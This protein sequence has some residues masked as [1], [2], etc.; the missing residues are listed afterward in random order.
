MAAFLGDSDFPTSALPYFK[1]ARII[2]FHQLYQMYSKLAF[3][4]P[5]DRSVALIGLEKR[6]SRTFDTRVE[7]GIVEK[8][9]ERDLLWR[10]DR[11][12][13]MLTR[14]DYP[15]ARRV[16]SWSWMAYSG[17]IEYLPVPFDETEWCRENIN[18]PLDG[19]SMRQAEASGGAE[20]RV[21]VNSM[22]MSGIDVRARIFRD[23]E[24]DKVDEPSL[25]CVII[26]RGKAG[27]ETEDGQIHYVLVVRPLGTA[28]HYE[29]V[30]VGCLFARHIREQPR[31]WVTLR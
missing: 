24:D 18:R 27:R 26:G 4:V 10:R 20:L 16:P 30:G 3:T 22:T 14:I 19:G 21:A 17:E 6:L 8:Y 29:R 13:D 5:T 12:G 11:K 25:G 31:R 9:M 28:N 23:N 15:S 1:G 2:L 7:Y